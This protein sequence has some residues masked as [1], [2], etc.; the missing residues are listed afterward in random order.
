M[1][2]TFKTRLDI[3]KDI[4]T[5][6]FQAERKVEHTAGQFIRINLEHPDPDER[7]T[8]RFFTLSASPTEDHLAITT[9]FANP[10]SSF[11]TA[12]KNLKT[13]QEVTISH[14]EGDFT[15]PRDEQQPLVFV[16]GGI[17]VTPYRSMLKF[18]QDSGASR[19]IHLIYAAK[20]PAQI[21]FKDL[22]D[23]LDWLKTT[24]VIDSPPKGW[25]GETGQLDGQRIKEL[26]GGWDDGKLIYLSGPEPM[27]EAFEK[28][29]LELGVPKKQLMTDF[30]PNYT[31]I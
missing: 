18:L 5:F 3:A 10:S 26:G 1:K 16:A 31:E 14:P 12:L 11:K 13:G 9:K 23:G 7:G 4:F 21:A 2:V 8:S 19:N 24:Y 17:G 22:F 25:A 20:E 29:L 6:Q 30:F 28:Q 27:I 15:L